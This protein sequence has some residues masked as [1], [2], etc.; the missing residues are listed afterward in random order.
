MITL[1]EW[2]KNPDGGTFRY[3]DGQWYAFQ[4]Y[5]DDNTIVWE[6]IDEDQ[7]PL[8]VREKVKP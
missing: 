7:V 2:I 8:A 5:R 6:K 1:P 4:G 3:L